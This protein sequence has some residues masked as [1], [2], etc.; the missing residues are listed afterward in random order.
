MAA[1]ALAP[2]LDVP[3]RRRTRPLLLQMTNVSRSRSR[4]RRSD[5]WLPAAHCPTE[6]SL[7]AVKKKGKVLFSTLNYP[8]S[9]IFNLELQNQT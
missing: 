1:S 3:M 9:P 4:P 6:P 8:E 2:T 7:L 5:P